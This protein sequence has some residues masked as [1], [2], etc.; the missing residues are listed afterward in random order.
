L[1]EVGRVVR[2][3]HGLEAEIDANDLRVVRCL[4]LDLANDVAIPTTASVLAEV[5]GLDLADDVA[6]LPDAERLAAKLN[7]AALDNIDV[8]VC[9]RHPAE[10]ALGTARD[11]PAQLGLARSLALYRVLFADGLDDLRRHSEQLAAAFGAGVK[12]GIVWQ[13]AAP[14]VGASALGA[15]GV[16]VVPD[17][18]DLV[19]KRNET[20]PAR[21]VLH[22]KAES[23]V[24]CFL[25][26]GRLHASYMGLTATFVKLVYGDRNQNRTARRLHAPRA[27]GFCNQAARKG[28][29]QSTPRPPRHHFQRR[30]QGLR[31][32][33]EGVQRRERPCSLA[34]QLPA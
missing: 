18:V 19:A 32:A 25:V 7:D 27:L 10:R 16:A 11:A 20:L 9:E 12:L 26:F 3:G 33:V 24:N 31:S 28:V 1:I 23:L 6:M 8:L 34:D 21:R 17:R 29:D 15:D 14:Y 5:A 2:R 13:T 30:V 4:P 22:A